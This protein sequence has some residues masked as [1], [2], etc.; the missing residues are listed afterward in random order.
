M[1]I[2]DRVTLELP[3]YFDGD[4]VK[5]WPKK[6][7]TIRGFYYNCGIRYAVVEY[8]NLEKSTRPIED[9]ISVDS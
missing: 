3:T 8:D 5:D 9:W 7:G 6:T 2:G 1:K 4:P